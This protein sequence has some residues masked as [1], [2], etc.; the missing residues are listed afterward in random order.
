MRPILP[1]TSGYQLPGSWGRD[2]LQVG[3]GPLAVT[4]PVELA[5]ADVCFT[6]AVPTAAHILDRLL[7]LLHI[8][9]L[10]L[11]LLRLGFLGSY[12]TKPRSDGIIGALLN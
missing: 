12:H 5:A 9:D 4:V 6:V 11:R 8:L 1:V 7:R 3:G 10:L 2:R